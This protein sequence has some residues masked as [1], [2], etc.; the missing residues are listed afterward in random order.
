MAKWP[1]PT[2][3]DE[4]DSAFLNIF[5]TGTIIEYVDEPKHLSPQLACLG[6]A[7]ILSYCISDN[8]KTESKFHWHDM[9]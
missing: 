3:G 5:R 8:Y 6:C 4:N 2:N 1:S 7:I 9:T